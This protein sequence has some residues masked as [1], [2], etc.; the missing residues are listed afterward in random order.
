MRSDLLN[1]SR[2]VPE[3]P[4]SRKYHR[5]PVFVGGVDRFL[6][7]LRSSRLDDGGNPQFGGKIDVVP[8]REESIRCHDR[9][10]GLL[11]RFFGG[12]LG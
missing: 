4:S 9:T 10:F 5:D 7:A 8:E 2:S 1:R 6:V 11:A 3:M 12:D